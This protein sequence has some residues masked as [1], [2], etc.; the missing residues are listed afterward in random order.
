MGKLNKYS[1]GIYD[2][3]SQ[4]P[5]GKDTIVKVKDINRSLMDGI[6]PQ[7]P[8][9]SEYINKSF[10]RM[11]KDLENMSAALNIGKQNALLKESNEDYDILIDD[12]LFTE[13]G[14]D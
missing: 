4:A 2:T 11:S 3:K 7:S 9:N 6:L 12:N 5:S 10:S 8:I 1:H 13:E 14:G